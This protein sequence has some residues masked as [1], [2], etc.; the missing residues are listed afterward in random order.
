MKLE[1]VRKIARRKNV[2]TANMKKGE[3][4][5]AIQMSEGYS[6]CF[7]ML[8]SCNQT[9]CLWKTACHAEIG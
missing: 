6:P 7:D 3:I 4:I 5:R 9:G 8:K 1:E 2:N